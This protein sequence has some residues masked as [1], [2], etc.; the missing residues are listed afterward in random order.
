[1]NLKPDLKA[2]THYC[3]IT[4]S[5]SCKGI[6]KDCNYV[7]HLAAEALPPKPF[8]E[9]ILPINII[10]TYNMMEEARKSKIDR[11]IFASSNHT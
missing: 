10:G 11:F 5:E 1:M 6:F 8:I 3:D 7:I 9:K 4:D 2:I